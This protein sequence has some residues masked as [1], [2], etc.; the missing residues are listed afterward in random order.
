MKMN[1]NTTPT[2]PNKTDAGSGSNGICHLIGASR[3]PSPDARR[4]AFPYLSSP[5]KTLAI[6]ILVLLQFQS[7]IAFSAEANKQSPL[8]TESSIM[9]AKFKACYYR[10]LAAIYDKEPS[11]KI[12]HTIAMRETFCQH[13]EYSK[14][15]ILGKKALP[16]IH[17]EMMKA[18]SEY[19]VYLGQAIMRIAGW[20][21]ESFLPYD[22]LPALNLK[23][24]QR[25]R[26]EHLL[27]ERPAK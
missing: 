26:E 4:S 24:S 1:S 19:G 8:F 2:K 3:S 5:M 9:E 11:I 14:I 15:V 13:P 27:D 18:N 23:L 12:S 25:L 6:C 10:W 20:E 22:S 21:D 7:H 16:H 17:A